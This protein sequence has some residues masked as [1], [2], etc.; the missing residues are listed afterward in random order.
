MDGRR[1]VSIGRLSG[2]VGLTNSIQDTVG[3]DISFAALLHLGQTVPEK[4]L[5][6]VLYVRDRVSV[7]TARFDAPIENC[8]VITPDLPG[9]GIVA[10]PNRY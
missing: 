8:G 9:L 1:V 3:P 6:C 7:T 2:L 5:R 10:Q 4:N